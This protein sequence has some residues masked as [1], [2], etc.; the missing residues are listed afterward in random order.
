MEVLDIVPDMGLYIEKYLL[1][2][3]VPAMDIERYLR[4]QISFWAMP[5]Q[6]HVHDEVNCSK[7]LEIAHRQGKA[8]QA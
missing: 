1:W 2:L 8:E 7:D 6:G 5:S 3:H 4:V